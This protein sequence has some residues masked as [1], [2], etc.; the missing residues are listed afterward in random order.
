MKLF[1]A[2]AANHPT[3]RPGPENPARQHLPQAPATRC[4]PPLSLSFAGPGSA[5]RHGGTTA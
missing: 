4:Q 3:L 5:L 2:V 1:R